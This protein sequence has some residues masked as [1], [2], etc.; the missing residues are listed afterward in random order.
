MDYAAPNG[1]I[2]EVIRS[3]QRELESLLLKR[4]DTMRRIG[5]VKQT[6][7][8]LAKVF[9]DGVLTPEVLTLLGR[10]DK[11]KQPGFTRACRVIL[12]E[13]ASPLNAR[14]GLQQMQQQFP[15][16]VAR[17]KEPLASVT[18]VFNRLVQSGEV[19]SFV[20]GKGRRLW[21]WIAE[22]ESPDVSGVSFDG[23]RPATA[24]SNEPH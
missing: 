2:Q 10:G 17:H 19:R 8:G 22:K 4:A 11:R 14:Q 23:T 13:A 12:L 9:G 24:S 6:L 20:N 21:E 16:L 18:T 3:A 15:E 7:V 1:H 5:T